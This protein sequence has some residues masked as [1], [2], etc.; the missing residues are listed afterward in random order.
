MPGSALSLIGSVFCTRTR[1]RVA[2]DREPGPLMTILPS[3]SWITC[4]APPGK[5]EGDG[6]GARRGGCPRR[7]RRAACRGPR[8]S[9][10]SGRPA[11]RRPRP[12]PVLTTNVSGSVAAVRSDLGLRL[13]QREHRLQVGDVHAAVVVDVAV[14]VAGAPAVRDVEE[15]LARDD[16]VAIRVGLDVAARD[17]TGQRGR[18]GRGAED[19]L[20]RPDLHG[21]VAAR[22]ADLDAASRFRD[23]RDA[24]EVDRQ[25][26]GLA[27]ED[28]DPQELAAAERLRAVGADARA[29]VVHDRVEALAAPCRPASRRRPRRPSGR[30]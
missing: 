1:L 2:V 3:E 8:R 9:R 18:D 28:R 26:A 11:S 25:P 27:R 13:H 16:P 22:E 21:E 29:A 14:A 10:R 20:A 30:A 19:A 7:S 4:G 23:G 24:A 15:I 6:V 5:R 12:S 17:A